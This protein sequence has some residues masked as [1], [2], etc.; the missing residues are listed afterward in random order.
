MIE[1]REE[2]GQAVPVS[3]DREG[4]GRFGCGCVGDS[5]IE[6]R[7]GGHPELDVGPVW[8]TGGCGPISPGCEWT[9]VHLGKTDSGVRSH[10]ISQLRVL[11]LAVPIST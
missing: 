10:L 9:V 8:L 4:P 1:G 5:G 2:L 11:I 3:T 7:P 6:R